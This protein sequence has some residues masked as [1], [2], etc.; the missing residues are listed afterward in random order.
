MIVKTDLQGLKKIAPKKDSHS[1]EQFTYSPVWLPVQTEG[2]GVMKVS[3]R[4]EYMSTELNNWR[5]IQISRVAAVILGVAAVYF[6]TW[7]VVIAAIVALMA[8]WAWGVYA[9][10]A[11]FFEKVNK[12]REILEGT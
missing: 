12:G 9:R 3:T 4:Q 6:L 1:S 2:R 5:T 10:K 11:Y 8:G 7:N